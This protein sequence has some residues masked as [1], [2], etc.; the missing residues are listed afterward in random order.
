MNNND[1][2]NVNNDSTIVNNNDATVVNN[3]KT[4]VG[5]HKGNSAN[6]TNVPPRTAATTPERNDQKSSAK[7]SRKL[8]MRAV[9][10]GVAIGAAAG[11]GASF[12]DLNHT[13]NPDQ[14]P[15]SEN[16]SQ[17]SNHVANNSSDDVPVETVTPIEQ[18]VPVEVAATDI[19]M[20]DISYANTPAGSGYAIQMK[21][22]NEDFVLVDTDNDGVYDV[23]YC[24]SDPSQID[25][26]TESFDISADNLRYDDVVAFN[27]NQDNPYDYYDNHPDPQEVVVVDTVYPVSPEGYVHI[28]SEYVDVPISDQPEQGYVVQ[29]EI[30]TPTD[31]GYYMN[32]PNSYTD[33]GDFSNNFN[34]C[35]NDGFDPLS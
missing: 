18:E 31:N 24:A 23:A 30:T 29:N 3:S 33:T 20:G 25:D 34:D 6:D 21:V 12:I 17:S 2:T 4:A 26:T 9:L 16:N 1:K 11:F 35:V 14:D 7:P 15:S 22:N 32:D 28:D 10:G 13:D 8:N 27:N 19:H 5:T